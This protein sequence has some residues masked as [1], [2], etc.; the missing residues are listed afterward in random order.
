MKSFLFAKFYSVETWHSAHDTQNENGKN[1]KALKIDGVIGR[2]LSLIKQQ[3][4]SVST[5][6]YPDTADQHQKQSPGRAG[7]TNQFYQ[8]NLDIVKDDLQALFNS[9]LTNPK[10]KVQTE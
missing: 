3:L 8:K 1:L 2:D 6:S 10:S 7:L 9:F 5:L 4:S